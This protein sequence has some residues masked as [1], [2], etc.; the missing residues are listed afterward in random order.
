MFNIFAKLKTKIQAFHF[1]TLN[2]SLTLHGGTAPQVIEKGKG[3][4]GHF[5]ESKNLKKK[6]KFFPP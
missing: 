5:Y 3:E 1:S 2:S 6:N 4:R